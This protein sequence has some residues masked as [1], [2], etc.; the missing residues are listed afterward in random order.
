MVTEGL[1]S[2]CHTSEPDRPS[3]FVE[4]VLRTCW[5]LGLAICFAVFWVSFISTY[6][7][8]VEAVCRWRLQCLSYH[9]WDSRYLQPAPSDKIYHVMHYYRY[10]FHV[11]FFQSSYFLLLLFIN[12]G[13]WESLS[14]GVSATTGKL[15]V[16]FYK[17]HVMDFICSIFNY[18]F[19]LVFIFWNH[20]I[21]FYPTSV[22]CDL[23]ATALNMWMPH[24]VIATDSGRGFS[25]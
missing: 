25:S 8:W 6:L 22:V 15:S 2:H 11:I 18:L 9:G 20:D 1:S 16:F 5:R 24:G 10:Y 3:V 23:L 13:E 21:S 12:I 7:S 4:N 14:W 17:I 19:I